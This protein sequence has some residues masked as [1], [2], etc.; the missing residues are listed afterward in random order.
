MLSRILVIITVCLLLTS[1]NQSTIVTPVIAPTSS[2]NAMSSNN[3]AVCTYN[4]YNE[5][6][7]KNRN[8][9]FWKQVST[10][11]FSYKGHQA[12]MLYRSL[13]NRRKVRN[14]ITTTT[15]DDTDDNGW[16][17]IHDLNSDRMLAMCLNL[18]GFYLKMG[19]FLGTRYDFMPRQYLTKLSK[20]H[21]NVPYL[22]DKEIRKVIEA[23]LGMNID[24]YFEELDLSKPI[25][26]ASIAQVHLGTWK[27][28]G[29]K[30]VIKIQYPNAEKLMVGDLKNLRGLAEFLQRT[31]LKFDILSAIKE[32][33]KQ[34][35]NEFDFKR[36]GRNMK[37]MRDLLIYKF[38]SKGKSTDSIDIAGAGRISI[39]KHIY[40]TKK[41]LVMSYVEG[42]NL[43]KLAE[44][45]EKVSIQMPVYLKR[46]Y[47]EMLMKLLC[48]VWGEMIFDLRLVHSDPHPGNF[49]IRKSRQ[50][51]L[52][53]V[54][55]LDWGQMKSVSEDIAVNFAE[56]IESLNSNNRTRI[57]E[58][59]FK[60]DIKV[61]NTDVDN[62]NIVEAIAVTM[63]DTRKY[64]GFAASPFDASNAL[65][66]ISVSKMPSDLYFL[67]RTIQIF[68]GMCFAFDIDFS[69]AKEFSPYAKKLLQ[70][71]KLSV[72]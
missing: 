38:P 42:D 52:P 47:G 27:E 64:P 24:D 18:R 9:A 11:Y 54:G 48:R 58:S 5:K 55:I 29:E 39:P 45:K 20:L 10:I 41:C 49:C 70:H 59:F 35:T 13:V 36:E 65:R 72:V 67:V 71:N 50:S 21:D 3:K 44:M 32:L 28:T 15:I 4:I 33:Q 37:L 17:R 43:S 68:R 53:Q 61:S 7:V 6:T 60:L 40:S 12:K 25:G 2:Y 46:K 31:E 26:S 51:L 22:Q 19:Q 30:C 14:A 69:M 16:D 34:I 62:Y 23:E 57:I 66:Q 56:M 1:I 8:A 63:L